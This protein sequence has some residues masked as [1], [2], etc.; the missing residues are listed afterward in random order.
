MQS[1]R[2]AVPDLYQR[3]DYDGMAELWFDDV[4]PLLAARASPEWQAS[5]ADEANFIDATR[6]AYFLSEEHTIC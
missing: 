5:T 3:A 1:H 6:T 4:P 2:L